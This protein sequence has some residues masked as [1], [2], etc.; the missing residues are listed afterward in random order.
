MN[1]LEELKK[2]LLIGELLSKNT[3][4]IDDIDFILDSRDTD[5]FDSEWIRNYNI[6]KEKEDK[7]LSIMENKEIIKSICEIAYKMTYE[8]TQS[9]DLASYISDDYGLIAEAL[10]IDYKDDWVNALAK[11]YVEERI[12]YNSLKPLK[13]ELCKIILKS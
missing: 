1:K 12:P 13:G 6:I 4:T 3:F 5:A 2:L 11:E 8:A 7:R 10:I 9:S